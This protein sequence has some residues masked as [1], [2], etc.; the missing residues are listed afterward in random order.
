[1]AGRSSLKEIDSV[2]EYMNHERGAESYQHI[3]G[4]FCDDIEPFRFTKVL[5]KLEK[6]SYVSSLDAADN[7]LVYI[8]TFEGSVFVESGGYTGAEVRRLSKNIRLE[9]VERSTKANQNATLLLTIVV[10]VGTVIP[11]IHSAQEIA[12]TNLVP[13]APWSSML[14]AGLFGGAIVGLIWLARSLL[15]RQKR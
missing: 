8:I 13:C 6:D 5:L 12:R 15:L 11:A 2:L 1:M 7:S 10:A 9:S 14:S 3:Y 4:N